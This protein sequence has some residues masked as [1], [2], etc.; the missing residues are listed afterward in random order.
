MRAVLPAREACHG[1]SSLS[2][3]A[4]NALSTVARTVQLAFDRETVGINGMLS[5]LPTSGS[6]SYDPGE[7]YNGCSKFLG[8]IHTWDQGA[9]PS[10]SPSFLFFANAPRSAVATII[11]HLPLHMP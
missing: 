9:S 6:V 1:R 7:K 5:P 4:I 11:S 10:S 3:R 2:H 8:V